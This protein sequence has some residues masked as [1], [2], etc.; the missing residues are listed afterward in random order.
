MPGPDVEADAD[1]EADADLE[2]R[3]FASLARLYGPGGLAALRAAHVVVVGLGGV[4]SWC[5]E[6][7]ARS[8]VG[9]L[10]LIDLDHV[11]ESNLNRQVH[12][13]EDTIGQAKVEAMAAR[14]ARIA[15]DCVVEVV[16]DFVTPDNA[17]ERL[18]PASA[19]IDAVDQAGA[20]AAMAALAVA[21][22]QRLIVCGAAGGR[23]DPLRL[24][25][26][27]L[28]RTTGDALLASVRSRLRRHHG[29]PR[30][31][32]RRFGIEALYSD[33]PVL[34]R[35]PISG[36]GAPLACAGYGSAMGVTAAMGI[37]AAQRVINAL[38]TASVAQRVPASARAAAP[39]SDLASVTAPASESP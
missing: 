7:L 30:D 27:D 20:K 33:E 39:A 6:T 10:T 4:G 3:R 11:A 36:G 21:G 2:D 1:A 24:R 28:A 16:D 15:A 38:A 23:T 19:W 17:A 13:L 25:V 31:P 22:H 5:A 35:T 9:R 32:K 18:P 37:A 12:A 8:G 26:D 29:F 34:Q 14:I